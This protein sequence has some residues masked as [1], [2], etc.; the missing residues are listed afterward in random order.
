MKLKAP[1]ESTYMIAL[2]FGVAGLLIRFG[3]IP[4]AGLAQYDFWFVTLAFL[5]LALSTNVAEI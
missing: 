4:I 1:R 2:F 3:I 5:L